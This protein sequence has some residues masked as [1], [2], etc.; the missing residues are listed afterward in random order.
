LR[1]STKNLFLLLLLSSTLILPACGSK[2][3]KSEQNS[4]TNLKS[5]EQT[6]PT[7]AVINP[8]ATVASTPITPVHVY[9]THSYAKRTVPK[10][11]ALP[12]GVKQ[13]MIAAVT[14]L[15]TPV[16]TSPTA[17]VTFAKAVEPTRKKSGSHWPLIIAIIALAAALGFYFWTKKTPPHDDFPLPPMGGLSPVGG[18]TAMRNKVQ[19]KPKRKSIWNKKIF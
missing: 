15:V 1:T 12:Q 10:H 17:A 3:V 16:P 4:T 19:H 9:S 14:P 7:M 2:E 6:E 13:P 11:H 18:F 8:T 5:A